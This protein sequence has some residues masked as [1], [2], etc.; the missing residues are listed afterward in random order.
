MWIEM[1]ILTFIHF[2][3]ISLNDDPFIL[4][5]DK[6]LHRKMHWRIR[7]IRTKTIMHTNVLLIIIFEETSWNV[8]QMECY[9]WNFEMS[10]SENG[11]HDDF[12]SIAI[13]YVHAKIMCA[14]PLQLNQFHSRIQIMRN[15]W[16]LLYEL[17][18]IPM[19][20]ACES[21]VTIRLNWAARVQSGCCL[22][23]ISIQTGMKA[24][25]WLLFKFA[26]HLYVHCSLLHQ[27]VIGNDWVSSELMT[28]CFLSQ[29][30]DE[31]SY[32]R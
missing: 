26:R 32:K 3:V 31:N 5:N 21:Y 2:A 29:K 25:Y 22:P 11:F 16:P 18:S 15:W 9:R 4:N 19:N 8:F 28:R 13:N 7:L 14:F 12:S 27:Y 20:C 10:P 1:I 30:K 23:H 6:Y 17:K 24:L